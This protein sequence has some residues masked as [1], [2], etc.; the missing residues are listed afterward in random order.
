MDLTGLSA[1][2]NFGSKIIDKIFP[3]PAQKLAAQTALLQL[4]QTG[5][6]AQL[7]SD[8]KIALAQSDINKVEAGSASLFVSGA[9]PAMLWCCVAIFACNYIGVPFLAWISPLISLP[10]PPRLDIGEVLPVLLGMLGLGGYRTYE[11]LKGVS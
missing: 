2:F 3:D 11:K 8:T 4:E 7:D 9:R 10:P 1:A 5:Q 6:L